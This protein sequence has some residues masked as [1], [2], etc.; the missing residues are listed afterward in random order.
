MS[1]GEHS[2]TGQKL[3]F[4]RTF[5]SPSTG[6]TPAQAINYAPKGFLKGLRGPQLHRP[7]TMLPKD[8]GRSVDPGPSAERI[9]PNMHAGSASVH[10]WRDLRTQAPLPSG[11]LQMCT[12]GAPAFTFGEIC[13][14]SPPCRADLSKHAR[15]KHQRS[16]L[17]R[18]ADPGPSA[19]RISPNM[20]AGSTSVHIWRDLR[21]QGLLPS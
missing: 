12:P 10:I 15:R 11:S 14:P 3:C 9:S 16:Y 18:S 21:A 19:E 20:H 8:L 4:R 2:C 13:G 6:T 7:K 17:G 1:S 5:E